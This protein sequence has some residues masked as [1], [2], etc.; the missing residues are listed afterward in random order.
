[1]K[2]GIGR[3]IA[4]LDRKAEEIVGVCLLSAVVSL[5][6]VGVAMRL[7]M[8]IGIPWQEEL[9]RILY[10]LV[11]YIGAS[12]GIQDNDHI[13]ITFLYNLFPVRLKSIL[14]IITDIVWVAFN[15]LVFVISIRVLKQMIEYPAP[16]GVIGIGLHYV[17]G[18][19]PVSMVL[20]TFRV[21]QKFVRDS[22]DGKLFIVTT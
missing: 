22:R 4:F 1:M 7:V 21:I 17:F 16:T 6:F 20:I 13:R 8:K 14:R 10:V 19:I 5:I 12:Y 9:S 18:I 15:V 3:I 2:S 11:V